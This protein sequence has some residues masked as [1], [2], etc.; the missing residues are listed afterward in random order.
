MRLNPGPPASLPCTVPS[1]PTAAASATQ[2][3]DVCGG[4]TER[5]SQRRWRS[6]CC[7][8]TPPRGRF[9]DM[10]VAPKRPLRRCRQRAAPPPA[11]PRRDARDTI[12]AGTAR[13]PIMPRA[14]GARR[15]RIARRLRP[16]PRPPRP[17]PTRPR[18]PRS[19]RPP[20]RRRPPHRHPHRHR[21]PWYPA[22]REHHRT[23][24][25]PAG[26]RNEQLAGA[27]HHCRAMRP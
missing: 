20:R 15:R 1:R 17:H 2:G 4:S 7:S 25:R 6:P 16:L 18:H 19:A 27:G 9:P 26:D 21:H 24:R 12:R 14:P 23:M 13:R 3:S 8:P 5:W 22:G 10:A 11:H